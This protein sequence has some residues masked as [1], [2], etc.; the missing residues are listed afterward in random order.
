MG[1]RE[2][3]KAEGAQLVKKAKDD[4]YIKQAIL[5]GV[6]NTG[7]YGENSLAR[8]YKEL[9]GIYINPKE[10][11]SLTERGLDAFEKVSCSFEDT[12][13]LRFITELR[14]RLEALLSRLDISPQEVDEKEAIGLLQDPDKLVREIVGILDGA[15]ALTAN[16]CYHTL[17]TVHTRQITRKYIV[18]AYPRLA[19]SEVASFLELEPKFAPEIEDEAI[20]RDYTVWGHASGGIADAL[21]GLNRHI[22]DFFKKMAAP[23]PTPPTKDVLSTLGF[24]AKD[25]AKAYYDDVEK[26]LNA[27]GWKF[28]DYMHCSYTYSYYNY[29]VDG[30]MLTRVSCRSTSGSYTDE[31]SISLLDLLDALSPALFLG[32]YFFDRL[33]EDLRIRSATEG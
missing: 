21:Y 9:L 18:Q 30:V 29:D 22:W 14:G 32:R 23:Y 2:Y 1:L 8:V 16:H 20:K 12:E 27:I 13:Y 7:E 25:L 31:V 19:G 33:G 17:F 10:W 4:T 6:S 26:A 15:V 5:G 3:L 24:E 28:P 11:V